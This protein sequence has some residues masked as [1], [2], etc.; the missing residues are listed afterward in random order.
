MPHKKYSK[1]TQSISRM[2]LHII[3]AAA[4]LTFGLFAFTAVKKNEN[5]LA[6]TASEDTIETVTINGQIWMKENLNVCVFRNGD[7]I[8][9]VRTKEAWLEA[10]NKKQP[11][12]CYAQN[13]TVNGK[14]YGKLYNWYAVSDSRGLAPEGWHVA[15]KAEWKSL[16]S[17]LGENTAGYELKDSTG[18]QIENTGYGPANGSNSTGF[19]AKPGGELWVGTG[20]FAGIHTRAYMWTST[21]HDKYTSDAY[22]VLMFP[23]NRDLNISSSHKPSGM[24]VR[25][26][27]Y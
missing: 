20:E 4:T 16:V 22:G 24:S 11:A 1:K 15:T 7:T 21:E 25:C 9:E 19:T 27:K 14:K 3:G 13:D 2:K 23:H 18:W 5:P 12:W 10:G 6:V 26:I 8:P 17:F